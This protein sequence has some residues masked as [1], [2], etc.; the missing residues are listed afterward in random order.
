M[1][2]CK[3]L[4]VIN[5]DKEFVAYIANVDEKTFSKY[6]STLFSNGYTGLIPSWEGFTL[7][8]PEIAM[9]LRFSQEPGSVSTIRARLIKN[10]EEYEKLKEK[11][12]KE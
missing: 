12:N 3:L 8:S 11:L 5:T 1:L 10:A 9:N 2:G 6:F 4:E 7:V